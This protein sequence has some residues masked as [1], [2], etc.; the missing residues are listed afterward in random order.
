MRQKD[1]T[2]YKTRYKKVLNLI[3]IYVKMALEKQLLSEKYELPVNV[4]LDD[5][6]DS[7]S[8]LLNNE[9]WR[10]NFATFCDQRSVEE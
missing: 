5:L 9:N 10:N 4:V 8:E 3:E 2:N 7:L 1:V 6:I